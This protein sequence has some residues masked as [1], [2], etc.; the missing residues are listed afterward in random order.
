MRKVGL[1][2]PGSGGLGIMPLFQGTE[3]LE[4]K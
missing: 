2:T 4:L 1:T 3:I